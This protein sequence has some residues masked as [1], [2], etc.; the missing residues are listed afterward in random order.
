M[1]GGVTSGIAY[2][3]AVAELAARYRFQSIGGSSAGAI[4]ATI[5]AAAEYQRRHTGSI[6]GFELLRKLPQSLGQRARRGRKLQSL[7]QPDPVCERPFRI[8]LS[9]L[10]RS[11]WVSRIVFP[12]LALL[13]AYWITTLLSLA[14]AAGAAAA[15][16]SLLAGLFVLPI[17]LVLTG[18]GSL[19]RDLLVGV[20]Q[21]EYGLCKGMPTRHGR[22]DESLT[23]WLH[24]QIQAAAG[25]GPRD[26][27]L[28]FGDLW[29]APGSPREV[30]GMSWAKRSIDLQMFTTNL[31]HG[32]PYILPHVDERAR[33]FYRRTELAPYL[34][35]E[36]M[37]WM[38]THSL[39]YRP[40][41]ESPESDPPL[42]MAEALELRELPRAE[43]FPVLLAARL[44]LSFPLLLS[45]IPFYA[46]NYDPP[47]GERNFKRCIFSDGGICSNFPIHLFDGFA[48]VWPTFGIQLE[49][50][51]TARKHSDVFLPESPG[52]GGGERWQRF[53]EASS[54]PARLFGFA[55]ALL[56]SMQNWNDNVQSR[57]L[58]VR[59]R[60]VR[61]RLQPGEGG[62]NLSMPPEAIERI[63]ARGAEAG[64]T[65]GDAF[66]HSSQTTTRWDQQRWLR[67][68]V[69][70]SALEP[71]LRGVS[72]ALGCSVPH[73]TSY[74]DLIRR[75]STEAPPGHAAPLS[76]HEA[77][78]VTDLCRSLN[79]VAE[80]FQSGSA[81][82]SVE[83]HP[84]VTIRVRSPL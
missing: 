66:A 25:R 7:F 56:T 76:P 63:A 41:A 79:Q 81:D 5:T 46:V 19:L 31:S 49:D 51:L 71:Q 64:R 40:S 17:F 38:D 26:A 68:D 6:Q 44:S 83:P 16:D 37:S 75:F 9:A 30:L 22:G 42:A 23:P 8:F 78:T 70:L 50:A 55:S 69:L 82:Y 73:A 11:S 62:L 10:N 12:S 45:P 29:D 39:P 67:L 36:V 65:L 48:P 74:A 2:P 35:V 3:P 33:L 47:R 32:R 21:N 84:P 52:K 28:T 59:D 72:V 20:S 27:P 24:G 80:A 1:K 58:G 14:A 57:M 61:V 4:A 53:D 54:A 13:K 18:V 60:V 43:A 77:R 15:F 34:P